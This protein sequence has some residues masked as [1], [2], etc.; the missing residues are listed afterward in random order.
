MRSMNGLPTY[1]LI[2]FALLFPAFLIW[3]RERGGFLRRLSP[4]L[5]C[6]LA[7]LIIANTGLL[8]EESIPALDLLSTVAVALSIPLML[9]SVNIRKWK[10]LTG[11]AG[12][13][14]L[15]AALSVVAVSIAAHAL[16]PLKI[17]DSWKL[18]GLLVGVYTGGTPNLAAIK[19]AL[20]VDM[21][22][23]LA[24]HTSDILFSAVYIFFVITIAKKVLSPVLRKYAG[25]ADSG[26]PVSPLSAGD[27]KGIFKREYLLPLLGAFG[28]ALLIFGIGASFTLFIPENSQTMVVILVI[29]TLSLLAS[30]IPKIRKIEKSFQ[31]GEYIILIFCI[32]V[33]S[34]GD[35]RKLLGTA[36]RIFLYVGIVIFGS[37]IIHILLCKVFRIDVD[38]MLIT[39][40]SAICSPPFVPVVAVSIR[41]KELIVPGITTGIIGYAV[42]NYLGILIA[43]L[44]RIVSG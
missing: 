12:I 35:F 9:F 36:P 41:N 1:V 10:E 8:R 4:L 40:T 15:L 17:T 44:T 5:V 27:Y 33:G 14:M 2:I 38:T 30:L 6:Y 31:L 3:I 19:T 16:L 43:Q 25:N 7:G 32:V 24:V 34:L 11:G 18:P 42:G 21:T 37:I 13:S 26:E 22:T 39:S 23:Y 29:T 28:V 20:N